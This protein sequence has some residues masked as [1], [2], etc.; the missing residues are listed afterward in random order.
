[1]KYLAIVAFVLL[2][3]VAAFSQTKIVVENKAG[4]LSPEFDSALQQKLTEF[5]LELVTLVDFKKKCDYFFAELLTEGQNTLLKLK[6]CNDILLGE[7]DLGY[8]FDVLNDNNK[9]VVLGIAI[10]DIV[11][12]PK[13]YAAKQNFNKA[14]E[15]N[16]PAAVEEI[17]LEAD[18][19]NGQPTNQHQSRHVFTPTAFNLKKGELYYNTMYL[20]VHDVQYGLNNHLSIGM[21]TTVG[22]FP[23]YITPKATIYHGNKTALAIGDIMM[24]GTWGRSFFGNVAYGVFTVGDQFRNV[25]IG[26]GH[27][28]L[29]GDV[30]NTNNKALF[31]ISA[32]VKLSDYFYFITENYYTWFDEEIY[33]DILQWVD[34]P[35]NPDPLYGWHEVTDTR[36]YTRTNSLVL[37]FAGI[38]FINRNKDIVSYQAGMGYLYVNYGNTPAEFKELW[39]VSDTFI[40]I[41]MLSYTKKFG[42]RY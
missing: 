40:A 6:N 31:N 22:L 10:F 9:A 38:R 1:M 36:Y 5:N 16:P 30:N 24:I 15:Q 3:I 23:F 2:H 20:A 8:S 29:S 4:S 32:M 34:D 35:S 39:Q 14:T 13:E 19:R 26:A 17:P 27:L 42:N 12:N 7:K 41:P 37:G 11:E 33:R 25:S 21:G 28:H 18:I